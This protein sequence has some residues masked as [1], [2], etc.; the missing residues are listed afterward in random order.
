MCV[1]SMDIYWLGICIYLYNKVIRVLIK[2]ARLINIPRVGNRYDRCPLCF[3]TSSI[4]H[5]LEEE[6]VAHGENKIN[7]RYTK[8]LYVCSLYICI[9]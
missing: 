3:R 1:I 7:K 5:R 8:R 4:S 2:L 9:I 6:F